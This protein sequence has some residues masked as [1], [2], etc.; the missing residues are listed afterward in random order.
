[1]KVKQQIMIGN[2]RVNSISNASILQI[3]S[4]GMIYTKVRDVRE[5]Y[6]AAPVP[7]GE[8]SAENGTPSSPAPVSPELL[9]TPEPPEQGD[10]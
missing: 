9:P 3:G 10:G 7:A 1:M 6:P 4:S 8:G 2:L 5:Y